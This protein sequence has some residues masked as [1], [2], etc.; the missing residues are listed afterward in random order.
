M[1]DRAALR[2]ILE[3]LLKIST[4]SG[5][6]QALYGGCSKGVVKMFPRN[7]SGQNMKPRNISP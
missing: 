1:G 7:L 6:S 3:S 2:N 4:C 5:L